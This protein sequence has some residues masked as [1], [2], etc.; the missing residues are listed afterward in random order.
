MA[1]AAVITAFVVAALPA[2]I[3]MAIWT[4]V[5]AFRILFPERA[6]PLGRNGLAERQAARTRGGAQ[7]VGFREIR[8]D[9]RMHT[10]ELSRSHDL[11]GCGSH[12]I[13]EAWLDDLYRRR[14]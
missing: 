9:V 7:E 8:E 3:F 11:V 14:N 6:L 10:R 1:L 13:P 5:T 4:A 2:L 12:G